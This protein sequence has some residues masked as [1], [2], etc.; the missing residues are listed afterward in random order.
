LWFVGEIE[1]LVVLGMR[2]LGELL[3]VFLFR[4]VEADAVG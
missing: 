4:V 2:V 1:R 3:V